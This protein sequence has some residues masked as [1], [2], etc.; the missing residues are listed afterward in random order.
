[1]KNIQTELM[2]L[3]AQP[4][5]FNIATWEAPYPALMSTFSQQII[6]NTVINPVA[7]SQL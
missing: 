5:H 2:Q 1:M 7:I 6:V 3:T 4:T